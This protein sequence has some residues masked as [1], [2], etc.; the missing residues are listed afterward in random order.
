MHKDL[1]DLFE[2]AFDRLA[3]LLMFSEGMADGYVI[4]EGDLI[5]MTPK[6]LKMIDEAGL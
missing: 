4:R 3:E 2:K 5:Y 6:V 1:E